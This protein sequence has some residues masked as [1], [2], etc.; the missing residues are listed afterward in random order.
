MTK[1]SARLAMTSARFAARIQSILRSAR[2]YVSRVQRNAMSLSVHIVHAQCLV[3]YR[4]LGVVKEKLFVITNVSRSPLCYNRLFLTMN[5]SKHLQGAMP[6]KDE[7][8]LFVNDWLIIFEAPS[9]VHLLKRHQP[10][11]PRLRHTQG[12]VGQYGKLS[13][14]SSNHSCRSFSR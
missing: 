12:R 7:P 2:S 5:R 13:V 1:R 9:Q 4:A 11:Y 8:C 14:S 3:V 10:K 6:S